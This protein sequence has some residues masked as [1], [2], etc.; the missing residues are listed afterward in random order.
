MEIQRDIP[1][2]LKRAFLSGYEKRI[3]EELQKGLDG[4]K[5]S[6][7]YNQEKLNKIVEPHLD[8]IAM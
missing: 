8:I 4:E 5:I 1:D 3:C 6:S 7:S 2:M